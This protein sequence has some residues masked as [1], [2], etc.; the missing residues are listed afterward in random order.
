MRRPSHTPTSLQTHAC[1][2]ISLHTDPTTLRHNH[3]PTFWRTASFTRRPS[4]T[5]TLLHTNSNTHTHT[6]THT[7]IHT[8]MHTRTHTHTHT[9]THAHTQTL[10]HA[11]P[12]TLRPFLHAVAHT[13]IFTRNL[14]T[15]RVFHIRTTYPYTHTH[16][17]HP[18]S[19]F[20]PMTDDLYF[21]FFVF[22]K[23]NFRKKTRVRLLPNPISSN[24]FS[25]LC[26]C[27]ITAKKTISHQNTVSP[28][29]F[30]S[31][32]II[33]VKIFLVSRT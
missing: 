15:Q 19:I 33:L 26:V 31:A 11:V 24:E 1:R 6:R 3:T 25:V 16:R 17:H 30:L 29:H 4:Y 18:R 23:P 7:H 8:H 32:Q 27:H 2:L 28:T 21:F 22:A 5:R 14:Y 12:E 20:S 9:H 10:L 13:N